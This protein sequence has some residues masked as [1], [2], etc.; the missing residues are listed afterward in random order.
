M[1]AVAGPRVPKA[2]SLRWRLV[3][4]LI[5]LQLA[6]SVLVL[7]VL[8]AVVWGF[9]RFVDGNGDRSTAM[10]APALHH[11]S[12]GTLALADTP[13]ARL[14]RA[15]PGWW[16]V[17]VDAGGREL[18]HGDV[19]PRYA[20][21]VRTLHG[22][23]RVLLDLATENADPRA[24]F[25]RLQT[26]AGPVDV[27]VKTGA[28]LR[29]QDMLRGA[30]LAYL[31]FFAP[32][33]LFTSIG[34][35]LAV[36]WV[37]N[38]GLR[39]LRSTAA[40]AEGIDV[41]QRTTRLPLDPVPAEVRPLVQAINDAFD[42]LN[43]GY[44]RQERFLA[45]AAHELRTPI[46]TLRL[47]VEGMAD[48]DDPD[49][50]DA[51]LRSTSRL[52]TMAEQLLDL[53][54]LDRGTPPAGTV[55]LKALCERVVADLAPL[56]IAQGCGLGV[57]APAALHARGD[58]PALERALANL[59][60][61]A[62]EHGGAGCRIEV[63]VQ[64]PAVIEVSDSGPGIPEAER[65]RVVEPFHRLVP[66]GR[67]AGLGLHLVAEVARLHGGQLRIGGSALG[68]AGLRLELVPAPPANPR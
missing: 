51:L 12:D 63:A 38:R 57:E 53:Q 34:F 35:I 26:A 19:P 40:R 47:Q 27:I 29:P 50:R 56:A 32:M 65:D 8:L 43:H 66:R 31:V 67:G 52:A 24:R 30:G 14:L 49:T 39:G 37:V 22:V 18:R 15:A 4:Q 9:D 68:G 25:E 59:I 42:R 58:A 44:D 55:D 3:R 1:K 61:N 62:I 54:R 36:P 33:A 60:Q 5:A 28:P 46:T 6:V 10:L 64:A 11:A 7:A 45:D 21:L 17:A 16:F 23:D 2:R 20:A 41:A 13:A 48:G